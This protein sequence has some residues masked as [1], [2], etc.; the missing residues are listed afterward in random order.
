MISCNLDT[1]LYYKAH[2]PITVKIQFTAN[3]TFGSVISYMLVVWLFV[4]MS[5]CLFNSSVQSPKSG[6]LLTILSFCLGLHCS[7]TPRYRMKK[8]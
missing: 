3:E 6:L 1:S 4:Y 8:I 2:R 7:F 5:L